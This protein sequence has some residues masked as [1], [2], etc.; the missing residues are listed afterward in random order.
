[1]AFTSYCRTTG[2]TSVVRSVDK[3]FDVQLYRD[4]DAVLAVYGDKGTSMDVEEV[5]KD[6]TIVEDKNACGPNISAGIEVIF[7]NYSAAGRLPVDIHVFDRKTGQFSDEIRYKR[8]YGLS[9]VVIPGQAEI[10]KVRTGKRSIRVT[11]AVSPAKLDADKY[12][13][14]YRYTGSSKWHYKTSGSKTVKVSGLKKGRRCVVK[15]RGISKINGRTYK[16]PW[17]RTVK[18]AK[19]R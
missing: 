9:Y 1:M 13:L 3:P 4:A 10:K 5:L 14:A 18:S 11:A 19:I 7:G 2:K 8:G 17:S 12:Q 6:I 15:L 16:G